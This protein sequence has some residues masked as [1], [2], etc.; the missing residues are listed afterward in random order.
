MRHADR[1]EFDRNKERVQEQQQ[2]QDDQLDEQHFPIHS[3]S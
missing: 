2:D 1:R 3:L